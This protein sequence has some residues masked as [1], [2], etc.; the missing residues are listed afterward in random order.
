MIQCAAANSRFSTVSRLREMSFHSARSI[1]DTMRYRNRSAT[2]LGAMGAKYP[3]G[4]FH[5]KAT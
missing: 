4:S 2:L 1:G 5:H 3:A